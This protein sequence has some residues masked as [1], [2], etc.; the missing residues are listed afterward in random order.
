MRTLIIK[1][2][3]CFAALLPFTQVHAADPAGRNYYNLTPGTKFTLKVTS[4]ISTVA[5]LDGKAKRGPVPAGIPKF[6][7]GDRVKFSI[8]SK[9][10]LKGPDFTTAFKTASADT[11]VYADKIVGT[12]LPDS[13]A[14]KTSLTTDKVV[15][16]Q[17][18]FHKISGSGFGTKVNFVVYV[19]E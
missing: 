2:I 1:A 9:G 14:V 4:V 10:E 8:G 13:A 12:K 6:K 18:A 17:L 19:L 7:K 3:A 5:G 11:T 15:Y 16:T